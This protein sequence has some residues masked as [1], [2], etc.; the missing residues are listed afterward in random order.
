VT[1]P[2]WAA[3]LATLGAALAA[4]GLAACG[5]ADLRLPPINPRCPALA[6]A[7]DTVTFHG[8][9]ARTGWNPSEDVLTPASV[10]SGSFGWLWDS[11]PLDRA[12]ING[13]GY[14][15]HI[16]ASPLYV[17][18]VTLSGGVNDGIT[19]SVVVVATSNAWVYAVNAC[20]PGPAGGDIPA[21]VVLWRTRLGTPVVVARLDGGVPLGVL[22]TPFID[23]AAS[24]PRIYVAS[25]SAER[26]WQVHALGLADGAALPGWPITIDDAALGRL[27]RNGPSTFRGA[28]EMS[29]RGALNLSPDGNTLYVPFGSYDDG[30]PGWLVAVD[31]RA[32]R[33][34]SAFSGAPSSAPTANGG[35]W[36]PGG[37][38][39]DG[40]GH[41]FATTGNSPDGS[42]SAPGVWGNS[43]LRWGPDLVLDGT[44]TPFNYCQLDAADIDLGGASP[45]LVPDAG[46]TDATATRLVAFGSKQG[47]VYLVDRD[48]LPGRT[49]ARPACSDDAGADGSLLPP[50]PQPQFDAAGPLN[51]FGPYT[52][53]Y[54]NA[55]YGKMRSTPAFFREASGARDLFVTGATKAGPSSPVS[56]PPGLVRLRIASPAGEAPYLAIDAADEATTFVNPGSPVVTGASGE[57]AL[58]WVLDE[59]A[60]R[61]ASLLD[62]R[63]PRPILYA[64]DA[65]TLRPVWQ[66]PPAIL[67]TGGKYAT[68]AVAHGFVFVGTDRVQAFGLRS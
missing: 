49:D 23:R 25:A 60:A 44:Y 5:G 47:N 15:P 27:N 1:G 29:Q 43:L 7:V 26:G 24:P 18:G 10:S 20:D 30:G 62:A 53:S 40:D 35:I 65:A 14:A 58:V 61:S 3:S 19:A 37:P 45:L 55:D 57:G 68:P 33:I 31:T 46:E 2:A 56:V 38:A 4:L 36:G 63:T 50:G 28:A 67:D 34:L 21:G 13:L 32:A 22:G 11:E 12:W 51:V 48:R 17:D 66:S 39:V 59:N 54:G 52:D 64:V 8:D 9:R 16:Y 6:A 42:A 41:V